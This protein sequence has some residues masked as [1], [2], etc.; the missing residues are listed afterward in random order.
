LDIVIGLVAGYLWGGIPAAYLVARYQLGIDI[1]SYGTGNVGASNVITHVGKKIGFALGLFDGFVKGTGPVVAVALLHGSDW[2]MV[3]TGLAAIAGHNWSPYIRFSGGRGV[4]TTGGVFL[5]FL[6]F[7]E[8]LMIIVIAGF[9][10]GLVRKNSA[11]WL[12]LTMLVTPAMAIFLDRPTETV[13]M[14]VAALILSIA[15]RLVGN[16]QRPTEGE[17]LSRVLFYRLL[18]DRDIANRDEWVFR[19]PHEP[20]EAKEP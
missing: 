19:R 7:P 15:K 5:G 12:L 14:T 13:I 4:N 9:W 1:R 3:V 2:A 11:M 6:L 8:F 10:G 16:W 18:F 20:G 17:P